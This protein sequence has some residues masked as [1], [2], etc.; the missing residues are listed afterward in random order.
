MTTPL[1]YVVSLDP[2]DYAVGP[3]AS[4]EEATAYRDTD[5]ERD[6]MRVLEVVPAAVGW[7]KSALENWPKGQ[8]R[9][10]SVKLDG[11]TMEK[12]DAST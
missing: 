1:R 9:V 8:K 10:V 5:M 4:L 2:E 7:K 12:G 6:N 3:F 11:K